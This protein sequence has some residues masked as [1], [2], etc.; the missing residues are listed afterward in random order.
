MLAREARPHHCQRGDLAD[1][2]LTGGPEV[3]TELTGI[4]EPSRAAPPDRSPDAFS[5]GRVEGI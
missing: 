4:L 1:P 3:G 5:D 2:P